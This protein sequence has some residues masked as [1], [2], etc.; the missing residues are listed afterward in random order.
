VYWKTV[1]KMGGAQRAIGWVSHAWRE[2]RCQVGIQTMFSIRCV[3]YRR[4]IKIIIRWPTEW[5][6]WFITVS[7]KLSYRT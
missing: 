2:G 7:V 3:Q 1:P 5:D 4:N 6:R